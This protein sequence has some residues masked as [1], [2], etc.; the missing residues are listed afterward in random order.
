[1]VGRVSVSRRV[2]G[3]VCVVIV[4]VVVGVKAIGGVVSL[5]LGT[6]VEVEVSIAL[7]KG[8]A[9]DYRGWSKR[10]VHHHLLQGRM[11]RCSKPKMMMMMRKTSAETMWMEIVWF[12]G[13]YIACVDPEAQW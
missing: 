8:K 12:P 3:W 2:W 10:S 5:V 11:M 13:T 1:M 9:V 7:I 6:G 4:V